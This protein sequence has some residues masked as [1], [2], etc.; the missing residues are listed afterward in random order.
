MVD[1]FP[2]QPESY[3][4]ACW[5]FKEDIARAFTSENEG[6]KRTSLTGALFSFPQHKYMTRYSL[7]VSHAK[8]NPFFYPLV[9]VL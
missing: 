8:Q 5:I 2:I 4:V 6:M 1:H 7:T 3:T 9:P